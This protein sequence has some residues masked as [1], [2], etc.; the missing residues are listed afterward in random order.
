MGRIRPPARRA[1]RGIPLLAFVLLLLGCASGPKYTHVWV[2]RE[3]K[4][5]AGLLREEIQ[6]IIRVHTPMI[7]Y[8]FER[9]ALRNPTLGGRIAT[10]FEIREDGTVGEVKIV[11][12]TMGTDVVADCMQ[13]VVHSFLFPKPVGGGTV[14]VHYPW[15]F[16]VCEGS[17]EQAPEAGAAHSFL[18]ASSN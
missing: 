17:C 12:N 11:E 14:V 2:L 9:E 18:D 15:M 13:E 4:A 1:G 10:E 8:C 16:R 3:S 6:E 5:K 7:R